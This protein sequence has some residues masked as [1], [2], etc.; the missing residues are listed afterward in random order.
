MTRIDPRHPRYA[1]LRVRAGLA[2]AARE[3]IVVPEGL[4]AHGRGEAFDYLLGERTT[5]SARRA[6][7]MAAR[8]LWAARRPV[9]SVNGN[10]AALAADRIAALA[11]ARPG[12][13]VEVNLFHR[14]PGRARAIADRLR[15][16]G[17]REV[18][19]VRPTARIR[20]LPSDRAAVD[21]GGIAQADLVVIPLEDGDRAEALRRRGARIVAID[22]NPL[23]RTSRRSHLPIVDELGRALARI[24]E[25]LP[26]VR[27]H[28]IGTGRF[29]AFDAAAAR[30]AALATIGRFAHRRVRRA[31]APARGSP[32]AGA[33]A[34]R[35][36]PRGRGGRSRRTPRP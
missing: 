19:G 7:R 12:L 23:S 22:L 34:G 25:E 26:R 32:R 1:S 20:G 15:R 29:P 28:R 30:A 9:I 16:A 18:L 4:I 2:S 8:W 36:P 33:R 13:R 10:V 3:G 17:V 21:R 24:A 11:R 5:P 14:T 27:P 35:R 6:E 31:A